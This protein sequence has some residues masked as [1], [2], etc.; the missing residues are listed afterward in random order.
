MNGFVPFKI[1]NSPEDSFNAIVVSLAPESLTDNLDAIK[2]ELLSLGINGKILFDYLLSTGQNNKRFF[3][4]EFDGDFLINTFH[5]AVVNEQI[6]KYISDFYSLNY[7]YIAN[8]LLSEPLK[9]Y[10]RRIIAK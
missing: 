2:S 3:E 7:Q 5:K 6:K 1:L 8:S 10:Y 4:M 9:Y